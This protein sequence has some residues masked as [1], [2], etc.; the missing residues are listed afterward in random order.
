MET[1]I[2]K[3][4]EGQARYRKNY[5]NRLRRNKS[6][7]KPEDYVFLRA[8]RKD[9]KETRPKLAPIA[10]RPFPS[11][12]VDTP[13]KTVVLERDD[14]LTENVSR[15]RVTLA[16]SPKSAK[17]LVEDKRPQT[18]EELGTELPTNEQSNINQLAKPKSKASEKPMNTQK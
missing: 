16:P 17:E 1:A 18:D 4:F 2:K 14:L 12:D 3:L 11:K 13:D 7:I 5:E 10:K 15:S 8:E 9:Y 6:L